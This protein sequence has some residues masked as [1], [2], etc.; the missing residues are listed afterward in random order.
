MVRISLRAKALPAYADGDL[1]G[2]GHAESLD[3]DRAGR[4]ILARGPQFHR[5]AR[6]RHLRGR[7]RRR[8]PRRHEVRAGLGLKPCPL[9]PDDHRAR[10]QKADRHGGSEQ[11]RRRDRLLRRRIQ[12][13]RP[14]RPLLLRQDRRRG[15]R[16]PRLRA[17]GVPHPDP[18]PFPLRFRRLAS[19]SPRS[20]RCTRSVIRSSRPPSMREGC[21]TTAWRRL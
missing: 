5:L 4:K 3:R 19:G 17:R 14:V 2:E 12:F 18:G 16:H 15:H 13:L 7:G 21:A 8:R 10:N 1:G 20:S 6:H 11:T 9:A